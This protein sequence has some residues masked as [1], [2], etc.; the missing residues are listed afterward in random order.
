MKL[1]LNWNEIDTDAAAAG[2]AA[3]AAG[4]A[5]SAAAP[6]FTIIFAVVLRDAAAEAA[7]EAAAAPAATAS[8]SIS[9]YINF[10][11]IFKTTINFWGR[12]DQTSGQ[13]PQRFFN[14]QM[15]QKIFKHVQKRLKTCRWS[16]NFLL[17]DLFKIQKKPNALKL[18]WTYTN[19]SKRV[20]KLPKTSENI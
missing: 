8:V 17:F 2:A 10:D 1:K 12:C 16:E 13:F 3:A 4:A 6:G 18:I 20:W 14:I 19:T 15:R 5:A 9:F 7:A 11:I